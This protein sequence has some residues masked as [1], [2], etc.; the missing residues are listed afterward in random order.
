MLKYFFL[1]TEGSTAQ[2][3]TNTNEYRRVK[4]QSAPLKWTK[5]EF[6]SYLGKNKAVIIFDGLLVRTVISY[7]I[8]SPDPTRCVDKIWKAEKSQ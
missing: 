8:L 3:D 5:V 4:T 7:K 1:S 6:N 2:Y